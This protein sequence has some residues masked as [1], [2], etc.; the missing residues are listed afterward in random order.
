MPTASLYYV[1]HIKKWQS[2]RAERLARSEILGDRWSLREKSM[3][4][5]FVDTLGHDF[6]GL[7]DAA[8]PE[9]DKDEETDLS[10][11]A[12]ANAEIL[13]SHDP[14]DEFSDTVFSTELQEESDDDYDD[15]EWSY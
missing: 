3:M 11:I 7:M 4:R 5:G 1:G 9:S 14:E 12:A 6:D 13:R 2:E 8:I 10:M 15:D